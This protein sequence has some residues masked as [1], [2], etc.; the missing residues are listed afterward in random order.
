[1]AVNHHASD[2][3]LLTYAAGQ[4]SPAP[5]LVVASH[6]AMSGED[7]D[8][9]STFE[10][11]GGVLID[12]QPMADIAPDLFEATLARLDAPAPDE[13]V[14][15]TLDHSGLDM[16]ITLPAPLAARRIGRWRTIAP[17][18]RFADVEV[19][20]DPAFKV[21]LLRVGAGKALPQHGHSGSELTVVLKGR[22]SD[23]AGSYG[24]GDFEEEDIA[25]N[26]QPVVGPE[27]ECICLTAIE[28]RLM[29]KSWLAKMLMP[30]FG[31]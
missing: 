12:E 4:L 24:P 11:L 17:G 14:R 29:P 13:P 20:E 27:G 16:G 18:V 2:E 21:V 22:F 25:S 10:R 31:F 15:A 3:L 9:L 26:H 1:M 28:G 19:P 23:G 5:A 7:A 6:L 30:L 8:R